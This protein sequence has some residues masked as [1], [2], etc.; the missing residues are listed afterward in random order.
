MMLVFLGAVPRSVAG[1]KRRAGET[2]RAFLQAQDP[3]EVCPVISHSSAA[4]YV[5][6]RWHL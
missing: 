6:H 1:R 4:I 3:P 5:V 2:C